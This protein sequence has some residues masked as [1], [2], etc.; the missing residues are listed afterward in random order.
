MATFGD[1]LRELRASKGLSQKALAECLSVSKSSINMYEH[2]ERE[3]S[4]DMLEIIADFFNCD[5]SY[6]LGKSNIINQ[7]QYNALVTSPQF[8][9][10][11]HEKAL[12]SA[13]RANPEMQS[14]VDKLL[15]L[16]NEEIINKK[17]A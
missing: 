17:D 7:L 5:V 13:Y 9:I 16:E 15:G 2:G 3:P 14:A 6:L 1:R 12:I 10:S 11:A 4:F 8:E